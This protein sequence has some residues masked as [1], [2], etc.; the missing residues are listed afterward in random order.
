MYKEFHNAF[1]PIY[2]GRVIPLHAMLVSCGHQLVNSA[3]YNWDGTKRGSREMIVWQY[4]VGGCGSLRYHGQE[5]RI[6]PG[7]AMLVKIP[8]E[9][10]YYFDPA[11]GHWEF[12]YV[13]VNGSEL[14]RILLELRKRL[15]T[16]IL[17]HAPD[18]E[19]V[20]LTKELHRSGLDGYIDD[21]FSASAVSYRFA[22]ELVREFL[23][24]GWGAN[25]PPFIDKVRDHC[26]LH[27]DSRELTVD[28][29]AEVAGYSRYHFIR[30]FHKHYGM[31]PM[32]FVTDLK[33]RMAVRLLQTEKLTVKEV[34]DR[35]GFS[36]ASYFCK[37]F[38]KHHGKTPAQFRDYR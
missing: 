36:S 17:R 15:G 14:V 18:S 21:P 27:L 9:H 7:S 1:M 25:I 5:Y 2:P 10:C 30:Q 35:C 38:L 31:S 23:Q 20:K 22:M 37:V 11:N 8:E 24:S 33:M 26:L 13:T 19:A 3:E 6:E 4:T 29:L 34:A 28:E 32:E 12:F 16:P